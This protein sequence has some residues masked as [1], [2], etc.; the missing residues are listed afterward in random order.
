[1]EVSTSPVLPEAPS[2]QTIRFVHGTSVNV[3]RWHPIDGGATLIGAM[4]YT[5]VVWAGKG[6]CIHPLACPGSLT[7]CR[8]H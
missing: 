5:M 6:S 3:P 2:A 7:H 8:T 1:M 4:L